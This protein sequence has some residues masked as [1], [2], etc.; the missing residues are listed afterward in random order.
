MTTPEN[1][2]KSIELPPT[3]D[4]SP[5]MDDTLGRVLLR[6]MDT[7]PESNIV[8]GNIPRGEAEDFAA[9]VTYAEFSGSP[10]I[11]RYENMKNMAK[12]AEAG[13][14]L[15]KILQTVKAIGKSPNESKPGFFNKF[16]G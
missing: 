10:V 1:L 16:R 9:A 3:E 4:L 14:L 12:R 6:V 11:L 2:D 15:D 8:F 13:S 7:D 5:P